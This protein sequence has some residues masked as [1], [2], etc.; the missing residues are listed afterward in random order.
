MVT[1]I[2]RVLLIVFS[3]SIG[4]VVGGTFEPVMP[5]HPYAGLVVGAAAAFAVIA[6]EYLI[7]KFS[8]EGLVAPTVGVILGMVTASFIVEWLDLVLPDTFTLFDQVMHFITISLMLV[9]GYLGLS[10]GIKLKGDLRMLPA[11]TF[12]RA[13]LNAPK[14]LDTSV[15]IDG[16]IAD[17]CKLGFVEGTLVIPRFVL[18]ELQNIADSSEP[19]RRTRGRRGLDIL[20]EIQKQVSIDVRISEVDFPDVR[21]VDSKL[22]RLAKQ[23][24][25]K[26]VTNDFNLNKIAQ[27]QGITVLNVNDLANALKP[28]VLPDEDF[29]IK[30]IKEGK[31]P[32]QGVGYLDDGTMVVVENGARL[33]GREVKVTVTSVLQTSAGQMIFTRIK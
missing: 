20:N 26:I 25:A 3:A 10:V 1:F 9:L 21:E 32:G 28:I 22:V 19:L 30:I 5:W 8:F 11:P 29:I 33:I 2:A 4:Y 27:F 12:G 14:V 24:N 17:I 23:M 13:G 18:N 31:E 7:K 15:I 16:R 6:V